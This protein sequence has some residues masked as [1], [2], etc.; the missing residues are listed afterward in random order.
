MGGEQAGGV[1]RRSRAI[2]VAVL[3]AATG[4]V[5]ALDVTGV[6]RGPLHAT[7]DRGDFA[8][9]RT[10]DAPLSAV[11]P[12]PVL[13]AWSTVDA[14][15]ASP[16][17]VAAAV[18]P[19]LNA[20]AL[21]SRVHATVVDASSGAVLLDRDADAGSIPAST[22][23]ILTATAAL[24]ELGGD[25]RLATRVVL[26]PAND[27]VTIVGGGDPTLRSSTKA[28]GSGPTLTE[29]AKKT[30]ASLKKQQRTSVAVR[31]DTS[32]FNGPTTAPS[33]PPTY[34]SSGEVAPVTALSVDNGRV[35]PGERARVD[36]PARTAAQRFAALLVDEGITVSGGVAAQK[37]P[38]SATSIAEVLSPPMVRIVERMLSRSDNDIAEALAHLVGAQSGTPTF[39]GGAKASVAVLGTLGIGVDGLRLLDG[40]GLSRDNL[41]AP[42][43]LSALMLAAGDAA[44][45]ELR[46][47]LTGL[48]MGGLSGTLD[49]RFRGATT[50]SAAGDVRAKTGTLTGVVTL[51][52]A[53]VD[54]DGRLL[55]F[56]VMADQVPAGGISAAEFAVDRF[57]TRL[58]ACGCA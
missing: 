57:V 28:G 56:S 43:V 9:T 5:L 3:A 30:S 17:K 58:A 39:T 44:H 34:V 29:L 41:I 8:D 46:G 37:A 42:E 19:A 13:A 36:D 54:T 47:V 10:V 14:A 40:S 55:M 52:G 16:A 2:A 51:S 27:V 6:L 33:W 49:D 25:L 22:T 12:V 50:R 26:D 18:G 32:L 15:P 45:P 23:K 48:P 31:Y 4:T 20:P 11:T 38:P 24:S 21:G 53:I 35:E 7:F 1:M